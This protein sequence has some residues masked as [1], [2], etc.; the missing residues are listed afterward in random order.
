DRLLGLGDLDAA[1]DAERDRDEVGARDGDEVETRQPQDPYRTYSAARSP[2][3]LSR[4]QSTVRCRPA[5]RSTD[6]VQ[7]RSSRAS[8]GSATKWKSLVGRTD[9]SRTGPPRRS[10]AA[11]VGITARRDCRGP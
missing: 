8:A 11:I 6:G 3:G 1:T 4:S 9:P 2:L 5:R 7:P 10:C